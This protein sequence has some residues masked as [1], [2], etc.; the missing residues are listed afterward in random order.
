MTAMFH[1]Q[2]CGV[3][4]H[5]ILRGY[6]FGDR[7]LEGVDF[8]VTREGDTFK[9][10]CVDD[11]YLHGLDRPYWLQMAVDHATQSREA[12]CPKCREYIDLDEVTP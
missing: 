12:L 1:C 9:V 7:L 11:R 3:I 4:P 10:V 2:D 6:S 5:G 8:F